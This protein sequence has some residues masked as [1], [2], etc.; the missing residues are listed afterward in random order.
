MAA[1]SQR[2]RPR[3]IRIREGRRRPAGPGHG[4]PRRAHRRLDDHAR[5]PPVLLMRD[6]DIG[7]GIIV[8]AALLSATTSRSGGPGG[9]NVNKLE[10]KVTIETDVDALPMTLE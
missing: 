8:P 6:L 1:R 3:R 7:Q 9:Q 5:V 2:P 4:R 10:T